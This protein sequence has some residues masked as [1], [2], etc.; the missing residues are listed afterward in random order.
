MSNA[1]ATDI[2]TVGVVVVEGAGVG[3]DAI[4]ATIQIVTGAQMIAETVPAI[5]RNQRIHQ[6][7]L[8]PIHARHREIDLDPDRDLVATGDTA[9]YHLAVRFPPT[10]S[11][12]N[13]F[14]IWNHFPETVVNTMTGATI[15]ATHGPVVQAGVSHHMTTREVHQLIVLHRASTHPHPLCEPNTP[16]DETW[17]TI[18]TAMTVLRMNSL[19]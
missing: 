19:I 10:I 2:T 17:D 18:P 3:V 16:R 12:Q 9:V 11:N 6:G 13:I 14:E 15:L 5:M 4:N 1:D 7:V 8:G